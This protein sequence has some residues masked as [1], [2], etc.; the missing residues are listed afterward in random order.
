MRCG[1]NSAEQGVQAKS[2]L[3]FSEN[4]ITCN[5]SRQSPS[6][7]MVTTWLADVPSAT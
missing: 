3:V 2:R 5:V 6:F 7:E 4:E 1:K